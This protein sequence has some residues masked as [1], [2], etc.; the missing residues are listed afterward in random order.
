MSLTPLPRP[1]AYDKYSYIGLTAPTSHFYYADSAAAAALDEHAMSCW[2]STANAWSPAAA[3]SSSS[4]F[5][6][7]VKQIAPRIIR[8][9]SIICDVDMFCTDSSLTWKEFIALFSHRF[10]FIAPNNIINLYH[11]HQGNPIYSNLCSIVEQL[12]CTWRPSSRNRSEKGYFSEFPIS[13]PKDKF[14]PN[15][16][17]NGQVCRVI[18]SG[19]CSQ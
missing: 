12:D 13:I 2:P 8:S 10:F 7:M 19:N 6:T 9:R 1:S 3:S 17:M 5:R 11:R 4:S 15:K 14:P 16:F 18:L